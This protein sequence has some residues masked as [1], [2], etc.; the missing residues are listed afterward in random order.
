MNKRTQ[1]ITG[2]KFNY[3]TATPGTSH[4]CNVFKQYVE[5]MSTFYRQIFDMHKWESIL[6]GQTSSVYCTCINYS[7]NIIFVPLCDESGIDIAMLDHQSDHLIYASNAS[8]CIFLVLSA[9]GL[10]RQFRKS[11]TTLKMMFLQTASQLILKY[12]VIWSHF[13]TAVMKLTAEFCIIF[14][15]PALVPHNRLLH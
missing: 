5:I 6:V 12:R 15:Q 10:V 3:V 9:F 11:L 1:V 8:V 7:F 14:E 13:R 2:V 4:G